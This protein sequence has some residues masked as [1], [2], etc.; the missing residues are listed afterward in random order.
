MD[1]I[2]FLKTVQHRCINKLNE[3]TYFTNTSYWIVF[4]LSKRIIQR[5]LSVLLEIYDEQYLF[6]QDI[7]YPAI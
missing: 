1:H 7:P 4:A 2:A 3:H 5:T 6:Q